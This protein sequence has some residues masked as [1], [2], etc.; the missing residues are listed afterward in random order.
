MVTGIRTFLAEAGA[1]RQICERGDLRRDRYN[2]DD[3]T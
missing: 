3:V 1:A 2:N